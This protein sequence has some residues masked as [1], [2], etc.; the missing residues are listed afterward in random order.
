MRKNNE[1]FQQNRRSY[2]KGSN[3]D[4]VQS[5]GT[6]FK[7]QAVKI[8][9]FKRNPDDLVFELQNEIK[10]Y[11]LDLNAMKNE[12]FELKDNQRRLEAI[13]FQMQKK[14]NQDIKTVQRRTSALVKRKLDK[15]ID[16]ASDINQ[17]TEDDEVKETRRELTHF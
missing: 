5:D 8:V 17:E 2:Y 7:S 10:Y 11:K 6:T 15:L 3:F 9:P 16:S 13:L 14:H 1:A 12:I 4:L